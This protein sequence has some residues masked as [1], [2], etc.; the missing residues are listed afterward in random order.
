[1]STK[2]FYGEQASKIIEFC[3]DFIVFKICTVRIGF[4]VTGHNG[5][6]G[7]MI[8][9]TKNQTQYVK[10]KIKNITYVVVLDRLEQW[11]L[12]NQSIRFC[13]KK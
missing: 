7:M 11:E 12:I 3:S 8:G 4:R 6:E 5:I 2:E 13:T 9:L 1:M 10:K